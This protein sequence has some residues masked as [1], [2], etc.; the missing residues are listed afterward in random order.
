MSVLDLALRF[1]SRLTERTSDEGNGGV[2]ARTN[3]G[4]HVDGAKFLSPL[5]KK[6]VCRGRDS[7]DTPSTVPIGTLTV[8]AT[9]GMPGTRGT[10]GT[11]GTLGTPGTPGT[12]RTTDA[13]P[14]N[15]VPKNWSEAID[16]LLSRPCPE[17]ESVERW[18]RA[19]RGVE[20]FARGWAAKAQG[21]GWAFDELFSLRDPFVNVSLQGAAWFIG[22]STV[23]AITADAI[24]L[25]TEGGAIQRACRR[26][27]RAA[28]RL[29]S[30]HYPATSSVGVVP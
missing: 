15:E 2:P 20:Q 30:M 16:R 9:L 28:D 21:L 11:V 7:R 29:A 8:K 12:L 22:D 25:R 14:S 23:T 19:C 24:T 10:F 5:D 3:L 1:N 17:A 13:R 4:Q 27:A 18:A 26:R 6:S